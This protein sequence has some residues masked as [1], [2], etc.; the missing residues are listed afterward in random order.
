[1][2]GHTTCNGVNGVFDFRAVGSKFVGEFLDEVLSLSDS[3][4]V[5]GNDDNFFRRFKLRGVVF[6]RCHGFLLGLFF[7]HFLG[8]VHIVDELS[9]SFLSVAEI[10]VNAVFTGVQG[11]FYSCVTGF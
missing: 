1:M 9:Q 6:L 10:E 3:H 2:T 7:R 8:F 4:T 5:T 11:V